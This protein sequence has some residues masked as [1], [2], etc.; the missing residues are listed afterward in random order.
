MVELAA[1]A[2]SRSG[3]GQ[4]TGGEMLR[5]PTRCSCQLCSPTWSIRSNLLSLLL[6]ELAL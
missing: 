1:M 6:S 4:L 5:V 2:R 3:A